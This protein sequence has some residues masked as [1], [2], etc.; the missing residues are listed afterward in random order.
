MNAT[1]AS[2]PYLLSK[3]LAEQ[4]AWDFAKAHEKEID[5]T[6]VNP[7]YVLGPSISGDNNINTSLTNL[8][9]LLLGEPGP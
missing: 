5:L 9:H 2:G 3:R 6:V 1:L 4:A 7:C 8:R